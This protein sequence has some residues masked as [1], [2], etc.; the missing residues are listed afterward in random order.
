MAWERQPV[1]GKTG[2]L[3]MVEKDATP[4]VG[5]SSSNNTIPAKNFVEIKKK[6]DSGSVFGDFKEGMIYYNTRKTAINLPTGD[7]AYLIGPPDGSGNTRIKYSCFI[8]SFNLE[9]TSTEQEFTTLCDTGAVQ[10]AGIP[11][12]SGTFEGFV[13]YPTGDTFVV[14]ADR[15]DHDLLYQRFMQVGTV[16]P[17]GIATLKNIDNT[18]LSFLGFTVNNTFKGVEGRYSEL[19]HMPSINISSIGIGV[20]TGDENQTF[21]CNISPGPD[22]Q[23]RGIT[24]YRFIDAA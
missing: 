2:V 21:T 9:F 13:V 16:G 17:T 8:T 12:I 6:A 20:S 19:I 7:E 23:N 18:P 11:E 5:D 10:I 22:Q 15:M 3:A 4:I 24:K 14:P 1:N